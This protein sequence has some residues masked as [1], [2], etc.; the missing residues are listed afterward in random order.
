MPKSGDQRSAEM[1]KF[2]RGVRLVKKE[3]FKTS[4]K[5]R[6]RKS[7]EWMVR[8]EQ[9]KLHVRQNAILRDRFSICL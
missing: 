4:M 3:C 7:K 2:K 8:K 6:I 1:E 5:L 9:I